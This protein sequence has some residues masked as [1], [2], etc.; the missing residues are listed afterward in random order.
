[1]SDAP[2]P[3]ADIPCPE[4]F[5]EAVYLQLNPDVAAAVNAGALASGRSHY[6]RN[7]ARE[8]RRYLPVVGEVREPV[9]I[10]MATIRPDGSRAPPP[11]A[12][13]VE[14]VR[15]S[16]GGGV[17][18]TGW[19]DDATDP[20]AEFLLQGEGWEYDLMRVSLART[21]RR[22][23]EERLGATER[24]PYGFWSFLDLA[25][26]LP[27]HAA[28]RLTLRL[29]SGAGVTV[30]AGVLSVPD[31]DLRDAAL[32]WLAGADHFGHFSGAAVAA[33]DG[34]TG[35]QLV[36]NNRR[37]TAEIVANPFVERFGSPGKKLRGSLVVCLYGRPEF[38]FVQNALFAGLP[39]I[40]DYEFVYV[41]N[42]PELND[43]LLRDAR[44]ASLVHG[45]RLTL[46]LLPGN[47]GFAAANNVGVAHARSDRVV[48]LN[49]DVV[50]RQ[51]D[52]ARRHT[53]LL[54]ALPPE[55]TAL[56]GVPLYYADGSLMHGGLFFDLD[57]VPVEGRRRLLRRDLVRVE[58]YGKGSPPED[59][60]YTRSRPVPGV[61][62]AF[63]SA[64]RDWFERL[65][66]FGENYIFG[67]YEDAD[68]CLRSLMAGTA[69]WLH[70]IRLFHLEGKG[71][72]RTRPPPRARASSTAGS[73]RAPG[74]A[75]SAT[76]CLARRRRTSC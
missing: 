68:L 7:G 34:G 21:R 33:L 42:S 74:P 62:G 57:S 2:D 69:P 53:E 20:L 13:G 1:M 19:I 39:G 24:H 75:R 73:S 3:E 8:G 22:D 16:P 31:A 76:A 48:A 9:V 26:D 67:H 43:R 61:T 17:F 38:L 47:A 18:V 63:L 32:A 15:M 25:R 58:H 49:P 56:F 72:S 23:V 45:L 66:G 55:R 12:F 54:S 46:V 59:E 36:A 70:D 51:P 6:V 14:A 71:G 30:Q 50:P 65:G 35:A 41:C 44:I 5:D 60:T 64:R 52:W 11:A 37:L 40:D 27:R 29:A 28:C 4:D 10:T